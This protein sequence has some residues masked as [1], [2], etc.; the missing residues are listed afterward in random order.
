MNLKKCFSY[1]ED[2]KIYSKEQNG[3]KSTIA[4]FKTD[5]FLV[6]IFGQNIPT[7][8]QNAYRH[9]IIEH[10]ILTEKG[11]DF[12]NSIKK[13]KSEGIKTEPAFSKLLGLKGDPYTELLKLEPKK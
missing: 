8:K 12:L 2:F 7:D 10:R 9:M 3:I 4:E 1:K 11:I 13:L 5:N 6:E